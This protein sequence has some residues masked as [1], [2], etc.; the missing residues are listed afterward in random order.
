MY[1]RVGPTKVIGWENIVASVVLFQKLSSIKFYIFFCPVVDKQK[2][3][4][5]TPKEAEEAEEAEA[6]NED[7]DEDSIDTN[8]QGKF[9]QT[10]ISEFME[11][12]WHAQ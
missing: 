10:R 9:L 6:E 2:I 4:E 8:Q 1:R 3:A 5:E 12:L 7:D 11:I